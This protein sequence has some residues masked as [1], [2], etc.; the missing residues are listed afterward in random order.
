MSTQ[1]T[2]MLHF[3]LVES[4]LI[5]SQ[6]DLQELAGQALFMVIED[7]PKTEAVEE[8]QALAYSWIETSEPETALA[9]ATEVYDWAYQGLFNYLTAT[10]LIDMR[11]AIQSLVSV[12]H[13]NVAL[14]V[15]P[16]DPKSIEIKVG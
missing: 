5:N 3:P 4:M 6:E 15:C 11:N 10:Q 9:F 8:L 14:T 13:G 12:M 2:Y 7:I 16:I 1:L